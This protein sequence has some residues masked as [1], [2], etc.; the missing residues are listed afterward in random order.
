MNA[1]LVVAFLALV[2]STGC[3]IVGT[4]GTGGG[5]GQVLRSGNV[6]FTWS[7][8]GATCN[9]ASSVKSVRVSIP[10]QTLMNNGVYPCLV[11]DYP[12]VVLKDFAG[13]T[14]TFTIEAI[15]YGNEILYS[16]S[17]TFTV[18]RSV[19]V[20]IDL[21]P[22]GGP[23]SYA[24]LNWKFPALQGAANPDCSKAGVAN[25]LVSIDNAAPTTIACKLGWNTNP[26]VQTPYLAA[27]THSIE[28]TAV[29]ST[30]YAFYRANSTL[31]TTAGAPSTSEY[32]LVWAVGGTAV[33]WSIT[34]GSVAQTCAQA[35]I[36]DVYVNFVD[37]QGNLVYGSAGDPHACTLQGVEYSFLKPGTYGVRV[38][39][40]GTG[41]R[42]FQ[43]NYS[44]PPQVTVVAGQFTGMTAAVNV[45]M[46][47]TQ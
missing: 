4:G 16:G 9:Q 30:G 43:S 44:A 20:D 40:A 24:Y 22:V 35:G 45:Q 37:A 11:V 17:G 32:T 31:T 19:R 7:F 38:I 3:I 5:G 41:N 23:N 1:R 39:A 6:T 36:T 13:G 46:F 42:V 18:D 14:Y 26:G 2:S 10:G 28:L 21:T 25:V 8:A 12:G 47:R 27:G 29:D 34:D 15:G 33:K